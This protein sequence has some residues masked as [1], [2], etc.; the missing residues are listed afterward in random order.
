M[1]MK[2]TTNTKLPASPPLPAPTDYAPIYLCEMQEGPVGYTR[3]AEEAIEWA[4]AVRD[5]PPVR[6]IKLY[7]IKSRR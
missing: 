3:M 5:M 4:M 6:I 2:N 7:E 1:I